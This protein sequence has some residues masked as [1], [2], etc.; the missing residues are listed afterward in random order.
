MALGPLL[1]MS[2]PPP[3]ERHAR[4]HT[5]DNTIGWAIATH[6]ETGGSRQIPAG[7]ECAIIIRQEAAAERTA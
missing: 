6:R 1:S 4:K 7:M 3:R 2:G 5:D